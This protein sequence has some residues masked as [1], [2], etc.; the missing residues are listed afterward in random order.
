MG[1]GM[2]HHLACNA[3]DVFAA[4]A[5]SAFDLLSDSEQPCNPARP[6]AVISFRGTADL[7]VPYA[8]G[9]SNPPNGLPVTIH[10]RGA[11]GTFDKWSELNGCTG[12]PTTVGQCETRSACAG[13]VETTLCTAVGGSHVTGDARTGWNTLKRFT[14]P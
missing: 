10:F 1:G 8:G 2:S 3:A 14:L 7:I 4:V 11:Q 5:P 9:A 6:I 13:G 12:T